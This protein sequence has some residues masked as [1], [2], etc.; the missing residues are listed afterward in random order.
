VSDVVY[1]MNISNARLSKSDVRNSHADEGSRAV[2]RCGVVRRKHIFSEEGKGS[3]C[4]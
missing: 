3:T 1:T 2:G 4:S